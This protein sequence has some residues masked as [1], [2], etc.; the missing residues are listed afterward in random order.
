M[1]QVHRWFREGGFATA[2]T[3]FLVLIGSVAL[4]A[5]G[6]GDD[7][8]KGGSGSGSSASAGES[9]S[10]EGSGSAAKQD[11]PSVAEISA[12]GKRCIDMV[13]AGRYAD[14]I[15]P[16]EKALEDS[17][18]MANADVQAA[19]D[20]AK[21]EVADAAQKA[22]MQAAADGMSGKDPSDAAKDSAMGAVPGLG[23]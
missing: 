14:A 18:S 19:Y 6:G 1:H 21:A 15:S 13:K 7:S 11:M 5:C 22:A 16:C 23:K 3:A 10:A 4:I 12:E 9:G 20:E 2:A 17:A 8:A